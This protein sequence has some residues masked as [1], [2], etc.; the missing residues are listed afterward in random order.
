MFNALLFAD[1][2]M[3]LS[4]SGNDLKTIIYF[5][6]NYKTVWNEDISTETEVMTFKGHVPIRSKNATDNT[7]LNN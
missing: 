5:A 3:L 7:V 6:Q 2:Q 1:D 4:D